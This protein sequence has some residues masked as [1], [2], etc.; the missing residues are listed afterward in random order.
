MT[1]Y[2]FLLLMVLGVLWVAGVRAQTPDLATPEVQQVKSEAES[3]RA[4]ITQQRTAGLRKVIDNRLERAREGLAKAKLSGNPTATGAGTAAV[5]IFTEVQAS[6]EKGGSY[7]VPGKV[8][9]DLESTVEEFQQE[10]RDVEEKQAVELRKW[11]QTFS[12]KLGEELAKQ[13]APVTD[14]AKLQQLWRKLVQDGGGGSGG[15]GV[16][17]AATKP[18]ATAAP[19]ATAAV[20]QAQGESTT[21]TPLVKL[22]AT[23]RDAIEVVTVPL[24][25]ITFPKEVSGKGGMGNPWQVQVTPYQE[26]VPGNATPAWR[27]LSVPPAL[28]MDVAAW[29]DANNGWTIELRAKAAKIPSRH[30]VILEVD[31]AATR[32]AAGGTPVP[33]STVPVS[34]GG[35]SA[36]TGRGTPAVATEPSVA[37]VKVRFESRPEGATVQVNNQVLQEQEQPMLTPFDYTL[38]AS[39][40]DLVFRK[41]GFLDG[42]LKQV[43]PVAGQSLR[44]T[45]LEAPNTADVTSKFEANASADWTA[46]RVRIKKGNQVRVT[47]S[48]TWSCGSGGEMVDAG[49]YP[50]DDTYFKYYS[51]PM[52]HP[53]LHNHANYG[54]LLARV[55]PDGAIVPLGRQG[56]FVAATDGELALAINEPATARLDNRGT[57]KVRMLVGQ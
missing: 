48:G 40:V 12:R 29:P 51:D 45:L 54:Q 28:P 9:S 23:V 17:G 35:A 8:R 26:L 50:N 36:P 49:G 44:V 13:S 27:I 15:T 11:N 56:S 14:E 33:A 16:A 52:Q 25:G 5:K 21:W 18:A 3:Q 24:K 34:A 38:P 57:L 22:E 55:L 53:R 6:F 1:R 42:A 41:R 10:L 19:P 43:T 4:E 31:A 20:L 37:K 32:V 47:A 46:M 7:A 30:V 2:G 39:P